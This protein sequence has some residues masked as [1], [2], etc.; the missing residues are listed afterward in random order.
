MGYRNTKR[1]T[2]YKSLK[3]KDDDLIEYIED[4]CKKANENTSDVVE[5]M[6]WCAITGEKVPMKETKSGIIIDRIGSGQIIDAL[7]NNGYTLHIQPV[8]GKTE[9][10]GSLQITFER[11]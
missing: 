7:L 8:A 5:S 11:K 1:K 6:L 2:S 9:M 10:Y 4:Q 3:I